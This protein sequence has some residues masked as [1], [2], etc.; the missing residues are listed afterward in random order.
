MS[1]LL[2]IIQDDAGRMSSTRI[3]SLA[4]CFVCLGMSAIGLIIAADTDL[5]LGLAGI[6][7]ALSGVNF[8]GGKKYGQNP[9][10]GAGEQDSN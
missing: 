5:V 10:M 2:E 9:N 8:V 7:A 1:K 3:M 4:T 6:A